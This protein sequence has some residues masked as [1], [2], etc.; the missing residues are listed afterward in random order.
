MEKENLAI[1][2]KLTSSHPGSHLIKHIATCQ[3]GND[4]FYAL[5]PWAEGGSLKNMWEDKNGFRGDRNFILWC[6]WQMHGLACALKALHSTNYR[7]GDIKPDNILHFHSDSY[8]YSVEGGDE[9]DWAPDDN[10]NR[11]QTQISDGILVLADFGVSKQHHDPT[12]IRIGK[13][14]TK[15]TTASY[16]APETDDIAA[17]LPR[18]RRY[19]IWSLGCVYLEFIVWLLHGMAAIDNFRH[20]RMLRDDAYPRNAD[21]SFYTK[22][23]P[24]GTAEVNPAVADAMAAIENDPRCTGNTAL[25][26][27]VRIIRKYLLLIKAEKRCAA[28]NLCPKLNNIA[29]KAA[30]DS[31]YLMNDC[32]MP[33]NLPGAFVREKHPHVARV[34]HLATISGTSDLDSIPRSFA[35][36]GDPYSS[37]SDTEDNQN[38]AIKSCSIGI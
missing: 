36:L 13:T 2:K 24:L 7:H 6:L 5:F 28:E 14:F 21:A 27:L 25:A 3:I 22:P 9:K 35:A 33:L 12:N 20:N 4:Y 30:Q 19:D 29:Q 31:S 32:A 26:D 34:P 18:S 23:V 11:A 16:Q 8:F 1:L 37:A 15:A 17:D 38:F 10:G